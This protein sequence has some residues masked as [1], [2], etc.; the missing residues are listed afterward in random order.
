MMFSLCAHMLH[1]LLELDIAVRD[2][3]ATIGYIASNADTYKI[4]C[5]YDTNSVFALAAAILIW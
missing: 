2:I 4:S 5:E 1:I 3:P